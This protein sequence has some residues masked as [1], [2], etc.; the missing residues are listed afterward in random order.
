[1]PLFIRIKLTDNQYLFFGKTGAMLL[2]QRS[3]YILLHFPPML[4]E[5]HFLS[6]NK[7]LSKAGL[8]QQ[9]A[10][11]QSIYRKRKEIYSK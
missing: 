7:L 2:A 8:K 11:Y 1:M 10:Y 5:E 6:S 9:I 3:L 4:T